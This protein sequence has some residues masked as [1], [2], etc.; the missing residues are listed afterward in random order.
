M[1]TDA[2]AFDLRVYDPG[3]PLFRHKDTD[4]V[5]EPSD[6]GWLFAYL[7]ADN[8]GAAGGIGTNSILFPY[9]GQG[10]YVDL[11][12]GYSLMPKPPSPIDPGP[13]PPPK[14]NSQNVP[15]ASASWF[16]TPRALSDVR[17]Q[18]LAPGY[19]V[20]DTWSFHYE[21]NGRDDDG[22]GQVDE[23]ING[24]DD[25]GSYYD[26]VSNQTVQDIRLGPDDVGERETAPPY[27]KPLRGAQVIVRAYE[28]DSRAI[29][30]IR[31]SQHFMP[32]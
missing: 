9:V 6:R 11:G 13:L 10:S 17:G 22:N 8:M 30:Q 32:E 26:P 29:R 20:Y 4:T 25:V 28:R 12:Y 16:F 31:V 27:D 2:L 14:Y 24:L 3:A 5:L 1:M 21:N 23:G 7:H 18:Q 19:A 15:A